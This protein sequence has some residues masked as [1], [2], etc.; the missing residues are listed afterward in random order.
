MILRVTALLLLSLSSFASA[1]EVSMIDMDEVL[2]NHHIVTDSSDP[3]G[4]S[5][6]AG[7]G[8]R[9]VSL[10]KSGLKKLLLKTANAEIGEM[11]P[12]EWHEVQ[13]TFLSGTS[14]YHKDRNH[15]DFMLVEEEV[16]FVALNT[17]NDAYFDHP[18]MK[19]PIREGAF[20]RFKGSDPHRTVVNKGSVHLLGPFDLKSFGKVGTIAPVA[21][22]SPKTTKTPVAPK[23]AKTPVAP[24]VACPVATPIAPP[25][26]P[27]KAT[28]SAKAPKAPKAPEPE[29]S[30]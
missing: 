23:S 10:I 2:E 29:D 20:I 11:N 27:P 17:N 21:T 26:A 15:E 3:Y 18:D 9:G 22:K 28:K 25:I 7:N 12:S 13:T 6:Y 30:F 19:V 5:P 14:K 16:G 1:I 24:P 4:A 8:A